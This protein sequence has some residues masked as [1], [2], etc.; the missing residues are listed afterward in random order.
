MIFIA[1]AHRSGLWYGEDIDTALAQAADDGLCY[2]FIRV[3]VD[4]RHDARW[5]NLARNCEGCCA[6]SAATNASSLRMLASISA[7]WSK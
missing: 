7:R 4:C 2:M 3:K 6:R 5:S 1:G